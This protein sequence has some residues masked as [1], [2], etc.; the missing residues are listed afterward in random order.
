MQSGF[1]FFVL[2]FLFKEDFNFCFG[3]LYLLLHVYV[4]FKQV[5]VQAGLGSLTW[6]VLGH[7]FSHDKNL[8]LKFHKNS[9]LSNPD[10]AE[11]QNK[12]TVEINIE[13]NL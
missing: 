4:I 11:T 5:W 2:F 6:E 7:R 10:K 9:H 3:N 1:W 12:Y 13:I 8:L